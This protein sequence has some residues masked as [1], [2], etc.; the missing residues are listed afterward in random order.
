MCQEKETTGSFKFTMEFIQQIQFGPLADG[1]MIQQ[2]IH[3]GM[4][5]AG[6]MLFASDAAKD[7]K[8]TSLLQ[9]IEM[10]SC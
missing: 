3:Q 5:H 9:T 7:Y 8:S 6:K 10:R 1:P 4:S 2:T